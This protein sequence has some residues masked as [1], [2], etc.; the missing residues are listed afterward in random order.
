MTAINNA[1]LDG[2][3]L[4]QR[5]ILAEFLAACDRAG[6]P[7]SNWVRAF[8]SDDF[9]LHGASEAPGAEPDAAFALEQIIAE[10]KRLLA[11]EAQRILDAHAR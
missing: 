5:Q 7:L 6:G 3:L 11:S 4:A 1:S 9:M 2:W 8:V 10:E